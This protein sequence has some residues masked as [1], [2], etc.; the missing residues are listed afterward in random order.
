MKE[1][2]TV[3]LGPYGI[4]VNAVAPGWSVTEFHFARHPDPQARK[5]ELEAM[6]TDYC[7]M[8]RLGR[9]DEIVAAIAF[10][11]SDEASFIT[12]ATLCVDGGRVTLGL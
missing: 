5:A 9:P 6:H 11:A 10:L 1:R 2:K 4:R 3:E 7:L 8:G 12:A